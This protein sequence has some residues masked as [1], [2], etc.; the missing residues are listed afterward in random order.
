MDGVVT[1]ASFDLAAKRTCE[2]TFCDTDIVRLE[3]FESK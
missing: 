3:L 1:K 2:I